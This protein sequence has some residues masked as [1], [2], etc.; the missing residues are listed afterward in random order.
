MDL[1][2]TY[3]VKFAAGLAGEV[4]FGSNGSAD[5]Q[6]LAE[7]TVKELFYASAAFLNRPATSFSLIYDI[8]GAARLAPQVL[9]TERFGSHHGSKCTKAIAATPLSAF[10]FTDYTPTLQVLFH[11]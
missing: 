5:L 4:I 6:M 2:D 10:L 8:P 9:N 7:A 3:S 11:P 1:A